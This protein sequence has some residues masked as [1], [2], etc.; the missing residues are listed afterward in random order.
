MHHA[1][2]RPFFNRDRITDFDT[3]DRHAEEAINLMK[4]RLQE[5]YA[6]DFQV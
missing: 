6:I 1:A 4:A 2:S 3:F 5:G